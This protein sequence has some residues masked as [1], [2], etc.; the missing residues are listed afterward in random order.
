MLNYFLFQTE[1]FDAKKTFA[2]VLAYLLAILL[3]LAIHEF[4]HAFVAHKCGDDTAKAQ[5]R[6]TLN[7][8][9]HVDPMGFLMLLVVGFGWAKPVQINPANF[10][11][12]K[13]GMALVS[14]SGIVANIL[15]SILFAFGLVA[16]FLLAPA[17]YANMFQFFLENFLIYSFGINLSLAIFN[18]LPIYPLDGFNFISA[19]LKPNNSYVVFMHRYGTFVLLLLILTPIFELFFSFVFGI[20]SGLFT[21]ITSL[22]L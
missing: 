22:F 15:M 16:Y 2:F 11:S 7:P 21:L 13:K 3:A 9:R 19:F 14:I 8:L 4:A 18:M 10:K 20:I 17:Q 6:L 5:G 12:Y 1:D